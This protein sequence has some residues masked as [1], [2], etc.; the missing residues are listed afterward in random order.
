[1]CQ[2]VAQEKKPAAGLQKGNVLPG[3]FHPLI[4]NGKF[5][6]KRDDK[7]E[8]IDPPRHHGLITE[9]GLQPVV[10]VFIDDAKAGKDEMLTKLFAQLDETIGKDHD[11]LLRGFAVYLSPDAM[12]V[13]FEAGKD[14]EKLTTE[15]AQLIEQAK[16][17]DE[18]IGRLEKLA[19]P[20]KHFVLTAYPEA[21]PP[22]YK[23]EKPITVVVYEDFQVIA[24]HSFDP[25][26]M[27]AADVAKINEE[28][29]GLIGRRKKP[30]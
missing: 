14:K 21:G 18:L 27:T 23:L 13:I 4:V 30:L 7:G 10:M 20:F 15:P 28:V 6:I 1:V 26:M 11:E 12:N 5:G 9:F 25:G 16:K 24:S 29:R 19:A 8:V 2:V 3:P 17:R 22:G